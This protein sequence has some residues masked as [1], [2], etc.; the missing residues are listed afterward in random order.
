MNIEELKRKTETDISEFITKKIM[1][2]KKKTGKEVSDIQFTAR[3]KMTG[4][5][6]Y[7]IKITL[8]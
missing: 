4:L 5:E 8:I 2:L 7:D 3:E 1:E 6:S